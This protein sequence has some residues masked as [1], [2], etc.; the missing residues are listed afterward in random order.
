MNIISTNSLA[1][2]LVLSLIE[3]EAMGLYDPNIYIYKTYIVYGPHN[4]SVTSGLFPWLFLSPELTA[5]SGIFKSTV[6]KSTLKRPP[7]PQLGG[8]NPTL[9]ISSD[10]N[11]FPHD[12]MC[13]SPEASNPP[14]LLG[15]GDGRWA[16]TPG[17]FGVNGSRSTVLVLATGPCIARL[18]M[19]E[20][21]RSSR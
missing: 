5:M 18:C 13:L 4:G 20:S 21:P 8:L 12:S 14:P 3:S 16:V 19:P 11:R 9:S 2:Q 1:A 17:C 6:L 15:G 7:A 10:G